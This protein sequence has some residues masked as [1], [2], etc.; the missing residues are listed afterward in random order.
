VEDKMFLGKT[1]YDYAQEI[2]NCSDGLIEKAK[3]YAQ[4]TGCMA[5]KALKETAAITEDELL[6]LLGKL[7]HFPYLTSLSE[8][9]IE[10]SL[11]T[12]FSEERLMKLKM[13]PI[14]LDKTFK[15]AIV[16]P[17]NS[18]EIDD[19]IKDVLGKNIRIEYYLITETEFGKH[20]GNKAHTTIMEYQVDDADDIMLSENDVYDITADDTSVVVL[21][22]NK[23]FAEA[24]KVRASDVHI[25]PCES[26]ARVRFRID[27]ILVETMSLPKRLYPRISNRIKTMAYMDVNTTRR[28]QSGRIR[29]RFDETEMDM[30]VSTLPTVHGEKI[31][32][33]LLDNRSANFDIGMMNLN[34]TVERAFLNVIEKPSGI[35]IMTGPTGSGKST[36]LYAVMSHLNDISRCIVTLE[37]PVEYRLSGLIQVPIDEGAGLSFDTVLREVLRQDPD[38]ILIGE[39]RDAETARIAVQASNTGHQVF[40]TLHT[41]SA[42]SS[43]MRLV[44]MG[45]E[46]FM[47]N[48]TLNAVVNQRLVR[49]ICPHCKVKYKLPFDSPFRLALG[50]FKKEITLFHGTGCDNCQN[51]GYKGRIAIQELLIVDE[52]IREALNKGANTQKIEQIAIKNGMLTLIQDGIEKALNGLTTLEEIHRIVHFNNI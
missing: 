18:L 40:T 28:P 49:R 33:R 36:S 17:N 19:Y 34:P 16:H 4:S 44:E 1:I 22:V 21:A 38:T 2:Y 41:N 12:R 20:M 6:V 15:V 32:V 9:E 42:A 31:T 13:L 48:S 3:E 27:G 50:E 26:L 47:V 24:T 43:V 7:Y 23:I 10:Q 11:V 39:I 29:L 14:A 5:H 30:R 25:E 45:V 37:Q 8:V 52:N 51:T 46:P 35:V